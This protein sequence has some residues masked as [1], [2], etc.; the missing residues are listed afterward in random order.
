MIVN[1]TRK[2]SNTKIRFVIIS[3]GKDTLITPKEICLWN[4]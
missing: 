4:N 2:L 1:H 3:L